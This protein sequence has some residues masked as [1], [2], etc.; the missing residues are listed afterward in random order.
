MGHQ[1][2]LGLRISLSLMNRLIRTFFGFLVVLILNLRIKYVYFS[3]LIRTHHEKETLKN[4]IVR[5]KSCFKTNLIRNFFWG[6]R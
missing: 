2:F 4:Q 3:F 5:I 1:D 6:H